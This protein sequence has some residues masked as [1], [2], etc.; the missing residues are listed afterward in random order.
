M[1]C[2]V[3]NAFGERHK[4]CHPENISVSRNNIPKE[5][6]HWRRFRYSVPDSSVMGP[7]SY[8]LYSGEYM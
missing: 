6:I 1:L 4:C 7:V 5:H 8:G 2:F 3:C